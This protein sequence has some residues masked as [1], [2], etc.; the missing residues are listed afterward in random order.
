MSLYQLSFLGDAVFELM[1]RE[2]LISKN[3]V[4]LKSLQEFTLE[5]VTAKRQAYFVDMLTKNAI[6]NENELDIIR[7]GRNIKT[8][9]SPKNCD[10]ITYKYATAFE[11]L[12]GY[13]YINDKNRLD[14][15]FKYIISL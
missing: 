14:E 10:I 9:K 4:K 8:H 13:L 5:F 15:V 3:V 7:K 12:I 11:I 6:L 2:Y 1:V